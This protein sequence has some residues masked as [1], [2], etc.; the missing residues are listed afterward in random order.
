MVFNFSRILFSWNSIG[1]ASDS[2]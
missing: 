1:R 2:A